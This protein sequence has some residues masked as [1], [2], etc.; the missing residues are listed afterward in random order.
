MEEKKVM[1]V[2]GNRYIPVNFRLVAAT[3]KNLY[4]LVKNNQFR[5]DLYYRLSVFKITIPPL[6]DRGLDTSNWPSSL[7]RRS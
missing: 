4:E 5:E 3:N 2:G 1:R 6:R 7:L